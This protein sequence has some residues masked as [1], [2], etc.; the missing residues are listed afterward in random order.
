MDFNAICASIKD[1]FEIEITNPKTGEGGWFI[2]LASPCNAGA[3]AK[4]S[5]ILSRARKRKISSPSQEEKD[6]V[7]LICARVLGWR[8]LDDGGKDTPFTPETCTAIIANPLAY[9]LR[10]Q[11]FAALGDPSLPFTA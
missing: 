4:V 2:E 7:D 3:Q 9:W 10:N 1:S 11:L 8:G 6:S 5:D